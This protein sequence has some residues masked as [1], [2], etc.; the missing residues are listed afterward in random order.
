MALRVRQILL[1]PRPTR[2][3]AVPWQQEV[4]KVQQAHLSGLLC[5]QELLVQSPSALEALS[6]CFFRPWPCCLL[7]R[8]AAAR[9]KNPE[10]VASKT[11]RLR[12]A[13]GTR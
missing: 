7:V 10:P 12:K 5:F 1:A 11:W 3:R 2:V 13:Q 8:T 9:Q 6:A 4:K